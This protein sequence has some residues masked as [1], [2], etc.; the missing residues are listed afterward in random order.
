MKVSM[1]G[2]SASPPDDEGEEN[3]KCES[4]EASDFSIWSERGEA[5]WYGILSRDWP[6]GDVNLVWILKVV[7]GKSTL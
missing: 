2:F 6:C 3:L 7:L 5:R 1:Y 4:D